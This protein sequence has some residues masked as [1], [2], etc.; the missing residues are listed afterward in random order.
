MTQSVPPGELRRLGDR[1]VLIGAAERRRRSRPGAGAPAGAGRRGRHRRGVRLRQRRGRVDR[2]RRGSRAGAGRCR[3]R[4]V[5]GLGGRALT[6]AGEE[7]PGRLTTVPCVFDGPDLAEVAALCG[8]TTGPGGRTPDGAALDRGGHGI[9][10]GFR[11]SGGAPRG[12]PRRVAPGAV[13]APSVPA[14]SVALANGHAAVYPTASPGGWQLV[15]RTGVTLF[16]PEASPLR[17][18]GAR[19]PGAP[20]RGRGRRPDRS[21]AGA[22]AG[23]V[24]AGVG[25]PGLRGRHTGPACRGPGRRAARRGRGRGARRRTGRSGL[26]HSGQPSGRQRGRLRGDRAHRRRDAAARPGTV[27]RRRGRCRAR[28][29]R[30]RR[31]G[32]GRAGAPPLRRPGARGGPAAAGMPHLRVRRGWVG[33]AG[34]LREQRQRRAVWPRCR[35]ARPR[36]AALCRAVGP[37]AGRPPR[38]RR[39]ERRRRRWRPVAPPCRAGPA[40][41]VVRPAALER[42]GAMVFVVEA[43]SNRV[44]IRLRE[45]DGAGTLRRPTQGAS[46]TPRASSRARCRSPPVASRSSSCPTT[47]RSGATRCSRS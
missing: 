24:A 7:P 10:P 12:T 8:C 5:E 15:G 13:P 42:L 45:E 31:G 46:S 43:D 40:P 41:R 26:L 16:S 47:P 20:H 11:L 39:G 29:A 21:R 22:G 25:A 27:P 2:P 19:G 18:P 34:G 33:R 3:A 38:P 1:A 28:G 30:R 35:A 23:V 32:A 17:G 4:V 36:A 9:L 6:V 14:G 37:P 44:G